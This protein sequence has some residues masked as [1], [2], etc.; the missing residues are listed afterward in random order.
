V[1]VIAHRPATLEGVD[2]IVALDGGRVAET[3]T[4]PSLL[5]TN[6]IFA[7]LYGQYERARGWH[8]SAGREEPV[9]RP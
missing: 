9:A 3:G 6:G 7:R 8:L 1:I 5:K 2:F 4:P